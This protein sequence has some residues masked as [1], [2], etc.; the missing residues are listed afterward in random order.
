[1]KC[2]AILP[3]M[4]ALSL[5]AGCAGAPPTPSRT[6]AVHGRILEQLA[7]DVVVGVGSADPITLGSELTVY[8]S[9]LVGTPKQV[10]YYS[11]TL[12]GTLRIEQMLTPHSSR[13]TLLSGVAYKGEWVERR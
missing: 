10:P 6:H 9:T 3:A 13:A 11:D 12:T 7:R 1:M 4:I 8:Q 2:F 5:S